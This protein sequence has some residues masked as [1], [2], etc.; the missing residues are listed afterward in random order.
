MTPSDGHFAK[1]AELMS[2]IE[3]DAYRH[4]VPLPVSVDLVDDDVPSDA[5]FLGAKGRYHPEIVETTLD[6][7]EFF[8]GESV[9]SL[10][11]AAPRTD[12][13]IYCG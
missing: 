2:G 10:S 7:D 13:V 1:M 3:D 9:A 8:G 12:T 4:A 6:A 11:L 5:T